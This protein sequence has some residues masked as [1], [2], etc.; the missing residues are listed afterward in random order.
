MARPGPT[1][2]DHQPGVG[3]PGPASPVT[4]ESPVSACSTS[5]ALSR[6]GLSSPQVS[7]ARTVLGRT[8]PDSRGRSPISRNR[9]CPGSSPG[10]QAPV[11]EPAMRSTSLEEAVPTPKA[12]GSVSVLPLETG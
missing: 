8:S 4:W 1:R 5:T 9:R 6:C 2:S 10:R 12:A 7:K 3:C 11:G